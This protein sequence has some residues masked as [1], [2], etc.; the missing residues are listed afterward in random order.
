MLFL[1]HALAFFDLLALTRL[2]FQL[3]PVRRGIGTSLRVFRAPALCF[4][5][6]SAVRNLVG[7]AL[8]FRDRI[9]FA[10]RRRHR[11]R[12]LYI[13]WRKR[14][15]WRGFRMCAILQISRYPHGLRI[16]RNR[17]GVRVFRFRGG[18]FLC[19]RRV[20]R[21]PAGFRQGHGLFR[22]FRH[23]CCLLWLFRYGRSL[24]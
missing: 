11:F 7:I 14:P 15:L 9:D 6:L 21:F 20:F 19:E 22:L 17:R 13:G 23:A 18:Y 8:Q 10:S 24:P 12:V 16:T 5:G 3:A 4:L 2:F 1:D